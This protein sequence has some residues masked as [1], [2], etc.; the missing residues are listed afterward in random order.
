MRYY[1][2]KI[3]YGVRMIRLKYFAVLLAAFLAVSHAFASDEPEFKVEPIPLAREVT[4]PFKGMALD[5]AVWQF[6]AEVNAKPTGTGNPHAFLWI[7]P[8]TEKLRGVVI[9][10]FN[11]C[12]RPIL[13]NPAFRAWLEKIGW[14]C[15]WIDTGFFGPHFDHNVPE[16][17]AAIQ[18]V[19]DSLAKVTGMEDI[20]T[21]PFIGIG[22][23]ARADFGYEMAAW[24]PE[25]AVGAISYD[26]NTL[27]VSHSYQRYQHPFVKDED[28]AAMKGIPLLH[29]DSEFNGGRHN[30]KTIIL[31]KEFPDIPFTL[32]ADP[33]AGHFG[34]PDE[35]CDFLG[36]WVA[37]ADRARNPN[38]GLPL[39]QVNPETGWYV[40]FWRFSEPLKA[41]AAPVKEFKGFEGPNGTE[42]NWV[43]GEDEAKRMV[44]HITRQDGKKFTLVGYEQ[45]GEI[46]PDK[47]DHVGV[48]PSFRPEK[49]G[50]SF[51]LKG[52][53]L[54]KV[55]SG[56]MEGWA[57]QAAE[58]AIPHPDDAG[59]III[60]P[61]CGPVTRVDEN[62]MAVRFDRCGM[63]KR[64]KGE[65]IYMIVIYPGNNEYR[66]VEMAAV[67]KIP[68]FLEQGTPQKISF[69]ELPDVKE[70]TKE[71][72][73]KAVSSLGFPVE[74]FVDYGPAYLK[75]GVLYL[76]EIPPCVK[77][78]IE[79]KVTAWQYGT[80]NEP[81]VRSAEP[82][83]RT[84][85]IC[86]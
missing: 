20:K 81:K 24:C 3:H 72:P 32:L 74:Y 47:K 43:F 58:L 56:R 45:N 75:D 17:V 86:K 57:G 67:M 73:L 54:D 71:V 39:V 77:L 6:C 62:T 22:H 68:A 26:G 13:E 16:N 18:E 2:Q 83:T 35:T 19:F 55:P 37:E 59:R 82:V 10:Q 31:R 46:L 41:K 7:P 60:K 30:R 33:G 49:D 50:I 38:G 85:R 70:G 29:R 63:D 21:V 4:S 42:A 14:G 34:T 52:V 84:F 5:T 1:K 23:S 15:I 48:H 40:D 80:L 8:K 64:R 61:I 28:L 11:M 12:E 36:S 76:T 78:P 9:G 27:C 79:I 51:K 53:F 65:D 25:R 66:R 69:P 44:E